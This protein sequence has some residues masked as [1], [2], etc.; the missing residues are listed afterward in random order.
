MLFSSLAVVAAATAA[1]ASPVKPSGKTVALPVKRVSNV[2]SA[3]SLVQ[4][5][6]A[7]LNKVNGVKAVGKRDSS[8]S[9]TNDDVS[10]IA[11]VTIGDGTYNLIVDTGSSNTWCGA[12]SS[13]EP[14]STG[15]STGQSVSV[16][17]G[18]GSFSGTEYTDNVSFGGL[19]VQGQSVGAADQASGFNGVDGIIGFGPVDLTQNTV[20]G[21]DSVPTFMDNLY[22]QGSI[23]T[24]VLGVSFRPESGGDTDDTNGELTLGGTDSSKYSGSISYFNTLQSGDAAPYWGISIA[25]FSYGSTTLASSATGIVDT[26]TTLIYIPTK[27]Y[28]KFLSATGGSTDSSSG[29][30]SF[31]TKPTSN[32][33]IKFGSTTFSLTPS[34]YLVPTSQYSEFG[35]SSGQYYSFINDGGSSG[36][37]TIIGQ[38]F[39]ENYYS[40]FDT[41][42]A[43]IGFAPAV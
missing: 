37:D 30:S 25:S 1:L 12:Q 20:S 10:Y 2:K 16:S 35:L 18:S 33:N 41:T 39:L 22:S 40:V 28:N 26:G 43:R 36:V 21:S 17:Y 11:A 34:Q 29:L 9:V 14:S 24:E 23:S 42:N 31:S 32:F 6:Q 19:T 4:K 13:C 27:A 5:G 38:K 3:K 7:R 15:Q 8:G